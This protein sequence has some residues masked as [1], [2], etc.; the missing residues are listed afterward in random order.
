MDHALWLL[1]L[2]LVLDPVFHQRSTKTRPQKQLGLS[3]RWSVW[4]RK[5]DAGGFEGRT[6]RLKNQP[7]DIA[8]RLLQ[9]RS[10]L[11]LDAIH[12]KHLRCLL[13]RN[14]QV[15]IEETVKIYKTLFNCELAIFKSPSLISIIVDGAQL[16]G[17][18]DHIAWLLNAMK[19]VA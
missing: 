18:P 1:S 16:V 12:T 11:W 6:D 17:Q 13:C 8:K 7:P 4:W 15:K 14:D 5:D 9:L 19:Q 10:R 2:P 3:Q